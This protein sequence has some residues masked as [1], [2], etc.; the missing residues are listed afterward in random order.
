[1]HVSGSFSSFGPYTNEVGLTN[2]K[3]TSSNFIVLIVELLYT[4]L[5]Y[6]RDYCIS[7]KNAIQ[8]YIP[9]YRSL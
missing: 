4:V 1:M 3:E 9:D 5:L 8:Y 6:R 2:L 7:L